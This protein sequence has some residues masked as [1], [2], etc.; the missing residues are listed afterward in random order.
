MTR[1]LE[2]RVA[3]VSGGGGRIG[4][5]IVAVL[6][7]E[8]AAV[9]AVDVDAD[10]AR[11][12]AS[13]AFAADVTDEG[14]VERAVAAAEQAL[15]EIDCLVNSH[16]FVPNTPLLEMP[17]DE[18]D[19]V[20]AV[21]VRGTMLTCRALARRWVN[22]GTRGAIVNLSSVA[23]SSARRGA[24]HYCS[25]KA[26]VS[27]LTQVLAIELGPH[28]IRVNAVAPGVVLDDVLEAPAPDTS[29]YIAAMLEATPLGRTGS[30]E[31]I[32]E[33]AAF[34]LSDRSRYTTG[35]IVDVTGGAHSGRT[36]M[37]LSRRP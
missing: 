26:A 16:G 3:L 25:S 15:G 9:A 4:R 31:E 17:V 19:R 29:P 23:A 24:S 11:A 6:A 32:A 37:P 21:N 20:F 30:P 33:A 8:G 36:H 12:A 22:R 5:R 28:G 2:G 7:R 35:A 14:D 34:L 13:V 10:A 18:W 27:M 1:L